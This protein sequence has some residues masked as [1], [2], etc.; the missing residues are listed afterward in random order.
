MLKRPDAV[1]SRRNMSSKHVNPPILFWHGRLNG[2]VDQ[3]KAEERDVG[4]SA[5][6]ELNETISR[7]SPTPPSPAINSRRFMPSS[8]SSG[9]VSTYSSCGKPR[10]GT[11][12]AR[13]SAS[14][15]SCACA[16]NRAQD[17]F[18]VAR[19]GAARHPHRDGAN[20]DL[21]AAGPRLLRGFVC[22]G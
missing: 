20:H 10:M 1:S 6:E 3:L 4:G 13:P 11:V 8:R 7:S 15:R 5:A 14:R 16:P 2:G 9:Q 17:C 19:I 21:N 12:A 22:L 18:D